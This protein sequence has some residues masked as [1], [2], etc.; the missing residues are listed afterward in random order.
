MDKVHTP[1]DSECYTLSSEPFTFNSSRIL[2]R[3]VSYASVHTYGDGKEMVEMVKMGKS[4][5]QLCLRSSITYSVYQHF[6][7]THKETFNCVDQGEA[8]DRS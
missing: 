5:K 2:Q 3:M 1:S 4:M 6:R 8:K 7:N